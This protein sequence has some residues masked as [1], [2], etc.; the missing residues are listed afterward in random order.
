MI[1]YEDSA[2]YKLEREVRQLMDKRFA[3][4]QVQERLRSGIYRSWYCAEPGQWDCSFTITTIPGRLIMTGDLGSLIVERCYD[5]LP[6]CRGSCEST[7]YFAEKVPREMPTTEFSE[8]VLREW[9]QDEIEELEEAKASWDEESD[10]TGNHVD[11][12]ASKIELLQE[13][14]EW[15]MEN[16]EAYFARKLEDVWQGN[17]YP[18]WRV[19]KRQ[20]LV[21]REAIR[22]F[23]MNHSEPE[24]RDPDR[25]ERS[26]V[27][28]PASEHKTTEGTEL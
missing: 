27:R 11:E 16:G 20:F 7:G 25:I 2:G 9:I 6:W 28:V 13:T 1:K 19:W 26:A 15:D 8:D 18:N 4:F 22:W 5:M 24:I 23:A 10:P 14:L 12:I 17:D 3:S 21:Q